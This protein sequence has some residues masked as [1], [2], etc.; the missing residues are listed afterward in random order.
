MPTASMASSVV[1]K[2]VDMKYILAHT[3]RLSAIIK[4]LDRTT[5]LSGTGPHQ[6]RRRGVHEEWENERDK[7][8]EELKAEQG[9]VD[10][11]CALFRSAR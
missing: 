5:I 4:R 10:D 6:Q 3:W 1:E 7:Q 2:D 9:D 11:L 8:V